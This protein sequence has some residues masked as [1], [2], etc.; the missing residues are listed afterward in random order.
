MTS[1]ETFPTRRPHR[2]FRVNDPYKNCTSN[3]KI[4]YNKYLI[5]LDISPYLCH[6]SAIKFLTGGDMGYKQIDRNMTF[7]EVSL[8]KSM[9]HNRSLKRLENINQV[10]N[11]SQVE[12]I[13]MA[14]YTVGTSRE[15][16]D[17]YSPLM[18]L[19]GILLQKWYH[20][21]SDPELENQIND[22]ISF[23]KFILTVS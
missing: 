15:G 18:L 22:R 1:L 23:K 16:A 13:L 17:A 7:A 21:D 14:H 19:K 3:F 4:N 10:I 12:E 5:L 20:I 8:L 9:E 6:I 2:I 11:W